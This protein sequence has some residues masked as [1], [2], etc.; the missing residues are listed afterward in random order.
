MTFR[1]L[2][3]RSQRDE[4]DL[5]QLISVGLTVLYAG[6]QSLRFCEI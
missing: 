6:P 2:E 4:K 5:I 3:H 1:G